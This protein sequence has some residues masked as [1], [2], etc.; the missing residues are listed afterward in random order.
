MT[1]PNGLVTRTV[2]TLVR[3]V[4]YLHRRPLALFVYS[5]VTA[6]A[7][8]LAFL[9][10]FEFDW[11]GEYTST[12]FFSLPLLVV[13]RHACHQFFQLTTSRWRYVS[14]G[15]VLRLAGATG[16]GSLIFL[17]LTRGTI[18][19]APVPLSIIA[20]EALLSTLL[21]AS[22]WVAYRSAFETMRYR[23]DGIGQSE[24]RVLIIGAGETGYILAR[25]MM[26][27]NRGYRPVGFADDDPYKW[28]TRLADLEVIGSAADLPAIVGAHA[29]QELILAV[30]YATPSQMR[31][32]VE[33]CEG[34]GLPFRVLPS[35]AAVL[36]GDVRLEQI[37]EVQIEDLLGRDPVELELEELSADLKG[38]RVLV[39]GAAGSIGS[40]LSRQIALHHPAMLILFDQAET[41]LFYLDLDLA[42]RHRHL[43]LVPLI[44]DVVDPNAVEA[45]FARYAPTHVFH[46][47]AYKHVPLMEL[48]LR[49]AVRNNAVGTQVVAEASGRFR[50]QKFVLVSTDKAV[51]PVSVMGATKRLAEIVVLETQ[52][53]HPGTAYAAVRFGNVLGS[54]GSVIPLFKRQFAAGK[55]LTVTHPDATRYFMTI[56]EA[57]QLILQASL[58]PEIRGRIAMLE[59]GEPVRIVDLARN[60]LRLSESRA[61]E[62]A[63]GRIIFTGLRPGEK[64][65]EELVAPDEETVETIIPKVRLVRSSDGFCP[66]IAHCLGEWSEALCDG[67]D[68]DVASALREMFPGLGN[69]GGHQDDVPAPAEVLRP[70]SLER[71]AS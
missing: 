61:H 52:E 47:A 57:V 50:A 33:H 15:D 10:R 29:V 71:T 4:R 65:H 46:A 28:G 22:L 19:P 63:S 60:L 56:P 48:N 16:T 17:S 45:V 13:L 58:I 27:R 11:P 7:Y 68:A 51:R 37:R 36:A 2:L 39:T 3:R 64:L 20:L 5:G 34:T 44:G 24:K 41:E 70:R 1:M 59:M 6:V 62:N 21:T 25:E 8:L 14:V 18:F 66:V 49:Q 23:L 55:P 53:R 42:D 40:E 31:T 12:F 32:I 54:N 26:R 69:G 9:L 35:I 30:P 43:H 38:A 67:R